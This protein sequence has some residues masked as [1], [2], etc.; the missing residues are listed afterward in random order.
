MLVT[1]FFFIS[2]S[3]NLV[4]ILGGTTVLLGALLVLN[5]KANKFLVIVSVCWIGAQMI[6]M[7]LLFMAFDIAEVLEYMYELR[8][9]NL[10]KVG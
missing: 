1:N 6:L 4:V 3:Q 7:S 10:A 5:F 9:G 8:K 2:I